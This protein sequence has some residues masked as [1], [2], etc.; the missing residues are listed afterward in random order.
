MSILE[1]K[2]IWWCCCRI[3]CRHLYSD[4]DVRKFVKILFAGAFVGKYNG[5]KMHVSLLEHVPIAVALLAYL[6]INKTIIDRLNV[7]LKV[8]S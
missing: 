5:V 2:Q 4:F 8:L 1:Y 6:R 3:I 7:H